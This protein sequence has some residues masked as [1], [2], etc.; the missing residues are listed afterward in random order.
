MGKGRSWLGMK[1]D[2][3][4]YRQQKEGKENEN[5]RDKGGKDGGDEVKVRKDEAD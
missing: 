5:G 3:E 4:Y 1:G 2:K